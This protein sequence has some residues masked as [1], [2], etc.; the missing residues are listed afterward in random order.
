MGTLR[1]LGE[2]RPAVAGPEAAGDYWRMLASRVEV[3][4]GAAEA[5]AADGHGGGLA[6][7]A[8]A[9]RAELESAR[10]TLAAAQALWHD[11]YAHG[12]A[13][14]HG[15]TGPAAPKREHLHLVP[16]QERG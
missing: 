1:L 5:A 8:A 4:A 12:A 6:A 11:G 3:V 16:G 15:G 7:E 14:L 10:L 9:L 13:A 2:R